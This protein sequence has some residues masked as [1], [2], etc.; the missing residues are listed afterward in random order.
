VRTWIVRR[1][2]N[3]VI[4]TV[5][6]LLGQGPAGLMAVTAWQGITLGWH[7]LR[8][9]VLWPESRHLDRDAITPV[10]GL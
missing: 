3:M 5:A 8:T 10:T 9:C 4:L 6:L 2:V 1:N 7:V